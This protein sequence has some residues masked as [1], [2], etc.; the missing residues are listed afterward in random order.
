M[1]SETLKQD[2]ETL[3]NRFSL[4]MFLTDLPRV[5]NNAFGVI[6]TALKQIYDA[7]Q[8][9]IT[10]DQAKFNRV[11]ATTVI[12]KNLSLLNA[13]NSDTISYD[14]ITDILNR[15]EQIEQKIK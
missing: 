1:A 4:N 5:L 9:K 15:L 6:Q 14:T 3:N 10:S 2:I 12:A 13:D 11:E 7:S 8:D